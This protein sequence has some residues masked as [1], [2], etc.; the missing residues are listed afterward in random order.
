MKSDPDGVRLPCPYSYLFL[1]RSAARSR[2]PEL[3]RIRCIHHVLASLILTSLLA[4]QS[5]QYR[6]PCRNIPVHL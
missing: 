6:H 3:H 2:R 4:L 1:L 5:V